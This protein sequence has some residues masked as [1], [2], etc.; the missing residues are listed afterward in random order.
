MADSGASLKLLL[1]PSCFAR[2]IDFLLAYDKADDEYYCQRCCY[3]GKE[4]N[5]TAFYRTFR[6]EK[7][8]LYNVETQGG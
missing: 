6:D 7:Y 5:V 3:A 2:E 8:K 4:D 1:C